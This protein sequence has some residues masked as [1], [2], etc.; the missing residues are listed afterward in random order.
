LFL[1]VLLVWG[2]ESPYKEG[3]MTNLRLAAL[4][5][6]ERTKVP[7]DSI[8]FGE[9]FKIIAGP[10]TVESEEQTIASAIAVKK[11]GADAL[12]GGAFKPR[13]SPYA[14]QGLGL[15]G[16][17]I[18]KK[19]KAETGLPIVT[20]V[21]DSRDVFWV[22]EYADI[23]QIGARN[24]QNF[25]LLKEVGR[26]NRPVLLKRGMNSTIEEWL[27]CAE[28]ILAEGNPNVILCE[29]GIRTFEKYTRNT[30][31]ISSVPAVKELSHL[32]VIV[33]PSHAAGRVSL[34]PALSYAAVAAGADGIIV[35]VDVDPLNVRCDG[36]QT[37]TPAQF[38]V[39]LEKIRSIYKFVTELP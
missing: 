3:V 28:Y 36:D 31:D 13:S 26:S 5:D 38:S 18:L 4:N 34:I 25:S 7:V 14:F 19:A 37:L 20:E 32:P 22:S 33:D 23:L 21:I 2:D 24:M 10:C 27:N 16:L 15:K 8:T 11:A 17:Q 6:K 29:R 9:G 12:R 30:L 35:E 39:M 1:H